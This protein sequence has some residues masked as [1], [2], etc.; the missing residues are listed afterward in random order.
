MTDIFSTIQ[1]H[2]DPLQ[3]CTISFQLR[4]GAGVAQ[5]NTIQLR[6]NVF[7]MTDYD[8]RNRRGKDPMIVTFMPT[9]SAQF[10]CQG[11]HCNLLPEFA[12]ELTVL[13]IATAHTPTN[14]DQVIDFVSVSETS[15]QETLVLL[16]NQNQSIQNGV[17][18]V[19][20]GQWQKIQVA[21]GTLVTISDGTYGGSRWALTNT[22]NDLGE[23][24]STSVLQYSDRPNDITAMMHTADWLS[25]ISKETALPLDAVI[26]FLGSTVTLKNVRVLRHAIK[27]TLTAGQTLRYLTF[28]PLEN[29]E[30][31]DLFSS[32]DIIPIPKIA[33]ALEITYT[34]AEPSI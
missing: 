33:L 25:K 22:V 28:G 26:Q 10:S 5:P 11:P 2:I 21:S 16:A 3:D 34:S 1:P 12:P 30:I 23:T 6:N 13:A 7:E 20:R 14:G 17:Y 32:A 24:T 29:R 27:P 9:N 18:V 4:A 19:K 15:P 31:S 8:I